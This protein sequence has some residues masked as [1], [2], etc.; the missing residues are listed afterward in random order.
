MRGPGSG[1]SVALMTDARSRMLAGLDVAERRLELAGAPTNLLEAGTGDPLVL[2]HGGIECGGAYWA[3]VVARLSERHRLVIPDLPGLGES[4]PFQ[5]VNH[6]SFGRWIT[7]LVEATCEHKP[8]LLAHSLLGSL[9]ARECAREAS[10][11]AGL[12]IYAAP[13]VARYRMPLGLRLTAVR[14]SLRPTRKNNERF[15]RWALLDLDATRAR[16]PDWLAAFERYSLERARLT[17]VK[18]TMRTLVELGTR[19]VPPEELAAARL[20]ISMIWGRHDRMT[21]LGLADD[22]RT[23][24]GWPLH[25]VEGA[26]HAPHVERP[27]EFAAAVDAVVSGAPRAPVRA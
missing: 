5:A 11:W 1:H 21:P 2:L 27:D 10:R 24:F 19:R 22:A 18:R 20:P 16:V 8:L 3:P 17:H 25:V 9:A 15:E 7:E 12:V 6:G 23:R 13:G 4:D 14:F 26:G